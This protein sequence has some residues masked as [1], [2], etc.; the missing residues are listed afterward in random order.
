MVST[1]LPPFKHKVGRG[2]SFNFILGLNALLVS[3][4]YP[5]SAIV[6]LSLKWALLIFEV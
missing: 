6:P 1:H 5:L 2:F 3:K 4:V